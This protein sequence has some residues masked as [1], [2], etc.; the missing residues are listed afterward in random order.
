MK[1]KRFHAPFLLI[2]V[3][4]LANGCADET[5]KDVGTNG[6]NSILDQ[7]V[8][9]DG[10][11]MLDAS[12]TVDM[13]AIDQSSL[14]SSLMDAIVMDGQLQTPDAQVDIPDMTASM[15]DSGPEPWS[16]ARTSLTPI[17]TNPGPDLELL[18]VGD[19]YV[20]FNDLCAKIIA[21]AEAAS[22]WENVVC[23]VVS[24]GGSG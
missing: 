16:P 24:S 6:M 12:V 23:E 20:G 2:L 9:L 15:P 4:S 19:N 13:L 22:R 1:F 3:M 10:S 5:Q 11:L 17:L 18:I 21:L 14:D 8:S 7:S